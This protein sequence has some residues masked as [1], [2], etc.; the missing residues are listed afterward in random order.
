M[1]DGQISKKGNEDALGA[2]MATGTAGHPR[3]H[4][5]CVSATQR[6]FP[7]MIY[8]E[9]RGDNTQEEE[10]IST[11]HKHL[12]RKCWETVVIETPELEG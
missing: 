7:K 3:E 2:V 9:E 1:V 4:Q 5:A 8:R 10:K 12:G 11:L 6:G